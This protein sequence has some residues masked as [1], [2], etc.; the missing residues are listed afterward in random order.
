[1]SCLLS[2]NFRLSIKV[3]KEIAASLMF[4]AKTQYSL[5]VI[6][7]KIVF[8]VSLQAPKGR[9]NLYTHLR[10]ELIDRHVAPLLA[11]LI[12]TRGSI[13]STVSAMTGLS[14]FIHRGL[15]IR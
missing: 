12:A 15:I 5:D 8:S 6:A 14:F 3:I 1:M 7:V 9:G 4:L 2:S 13:S 11:T 10:Y